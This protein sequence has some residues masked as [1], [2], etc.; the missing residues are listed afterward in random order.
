MFENP[1]L[2]IVQQ[3]RPFGFLTISVSQKRSVKDA[4]K[5]MPPV[6]ERIFGIR[7]NN[8]AMKLLESA[9]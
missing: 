3:G 9:I 6:L 5:L 2:K 7:D 4:M 8:T 1:A